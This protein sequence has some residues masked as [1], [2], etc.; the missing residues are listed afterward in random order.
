[1][2]AMDID[3][4]SGR[5]LYE[6][7]DRC[8]YDRHRCPCCGS[9]LEHEQGVCTDPLLPPP[10]IS[11]FTGTW[12]FLS[13]FYLAQVFWE[14]YVYPTAEHAFNAGKTLDSTKRA[15]IRAAETPSQAKR[16]GRQVELRPDWDERVRFEVMYSVLRSKFLCMPERVQALLYTS[17][18]LLVEG[19]HWHDQT[20]G[21]C[22]CGRKE[23]SLPG[24]NHLGRLL[25]VVRAEIRELHMKVQ[26]ND[27]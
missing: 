18:A 24:R 27:F 23:C 6:I 5:K 17:D 21:D 16:R 14:G 22:A 2:K 13:N 9:D 4:R 3:P 20:W 10:T 19:N 8:N 11:S 12:A 7:C 26:T 1:M 15:W 25:M